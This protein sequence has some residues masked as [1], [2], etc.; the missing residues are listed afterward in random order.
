MA[1]IVDTLPGIVLLDLPANRSALSRSSTG[2][3]S[4]WENAQIASSIFL[5]GKIIDKPPDITLFVN[6]TFVQSVAGAR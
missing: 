2:S 1:D 6:D 3:V 4:A 5:T